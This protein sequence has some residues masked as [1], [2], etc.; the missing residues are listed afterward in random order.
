MEDIAADVLAELHF[1]DVE[2][3]WEEVDPLAMVT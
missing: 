2:D 1:I 3:L